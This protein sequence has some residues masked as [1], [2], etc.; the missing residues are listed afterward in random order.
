MQATC[1]GLSH[2]SEGW[3]FFLYNNLQYQSKVTFS[4]KSGIKWTAV[5][6]LNKIGSL[7]GLHNQTGMNM[8]WWLAEV[9]KLSEYV[10]RMG[11]FKV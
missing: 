4:S 11:N 1:S 10:V 7:L 8:I 3:Q 5:E 2:F 9:K 6:K